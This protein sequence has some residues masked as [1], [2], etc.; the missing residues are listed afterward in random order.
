MV[1]HPEGRVTLAIDP[2][3]DNFTSLNHK[4]PVHIMEPLRVLMQ[5]PLA[6]IQSLGQEFLL[7]SKPH[8]HRNEDGG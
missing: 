8:T 5:R 2:P 6:M 4:G 3:F 7:Q 1:S